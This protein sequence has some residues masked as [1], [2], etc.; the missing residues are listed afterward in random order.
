MDPIIYPLQNFAVCSPSAA[1]GG[2]GKILGGIAQS[3]QIKAQNAAKK[4][5]YERR[6]EIRKRGWLQKSTLYSAKINKYNIDLNEN[7][8]AA[9]RGYAKA[10]YELGAKQ[11]A[12]IAGNETS[13]MK[14]VKDKLGKT[15]AGGTT[16][17]SAARAEKLFLAEY[18]REVAKR[19]FA[20]TRSGEAYQDN[21]E[22]IRRKQVSNRNQL[23]AGV[24]FQPVPD[25]AP[26]PPQMQNS[27]MPILQGIIGAAAGAAGAMEDAQ[28]MNTGLE[29]N[30]GFNYTETGWSSS[31]GGF[32]DYSM[33]INPWSTSFDS[34]SAWD[35]KL[36]I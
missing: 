19:A 36:N 9:Q 20:L 22:N 15:A 26:N 4:R 12:A 25:L 17:R 35:L 13:F 6:L 32:D 1:I 8:M 31:I 33:D 11:S 21:V 29:N 16:G 34:S 3:Q 23:Y 5:E 27:S 10:Q 24:A 28:D 30:T 2:A 7:D 18:G 14:Y